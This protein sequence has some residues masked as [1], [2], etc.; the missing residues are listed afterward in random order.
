MR[1]VTVRGFMLPSE[2]DEAR[3]WFIANINTPVFR[4]DKHQT[5]YTTRYTPDSNLPSVIDDVFGRVIKQFSFSPLCRKEI[6]TD[7]SGVICLAQFSGAATPMHYDR[8]H[9]AQ[10]DMSI[11]RFNI[12][13]EDAN[14]GVLSIE[15]SEGDVVEYKAEVGELHAYNVS[16]FKHGVS[17]VAG[18]R[19]IVLFSMCVPY[20]EWEDGL[21]KYE[22]DLPCIEFI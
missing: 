10:Q 3:E 9:S 11:I 19:F 6:T 16:E 7:G 1:R 12:V 18:R 17:S 2:V 15:N 8:K 20:G 14:G 22:G 5:S 21:I 13:I 4:S